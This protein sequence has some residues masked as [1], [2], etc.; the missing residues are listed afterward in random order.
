MPTKSQIAARKQKIQKAG[1]LFTM[2][3]DN[4]TSVIAEIMGLHPASVSDYIDEFLKQKGI[5]KDG[6]L[7][8]E[9]KMNNPDFLI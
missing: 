9:S 1:E 2:L 8:L 5:K 7:I 3:K 4:R 6:Y